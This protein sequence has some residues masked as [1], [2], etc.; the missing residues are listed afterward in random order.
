MTKPFTTILLAVTTALWVGAAA[1]EEHGHMHPHFAPDIDAFHTL[2]API[3]HNQPG[4]ARSRNACAQA[5]KMSESAAQIR[6]ADARA[7]VATI[8]NL[9][10]TCKTKP[11]AVDTALSDVHEAFHRLIE[12][13]PPASAR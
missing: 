13:P 9:K 4:K 8:A 10:S 1:A 3:W 7:L 5:G 2:L 6:S 12:T 11:T